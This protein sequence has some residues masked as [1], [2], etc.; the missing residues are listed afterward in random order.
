MP[1]GMDD[2]DKEDIRGLSGLLSTAPSCAKVSGDIMMYNHVLRV[3]AHDS[4]ASWF[5]AAHGPQIKRTQRW[6]ERVRGHVGGN[7]TGLS[8]TW[9]GTSSGAPTL[10]RNNSGIALRSG[11]GDDE[12]VM[13]VDCG[14]P[15]RTSPHLTLMH[16]S[17]CFWR[18]SCSRRSLDRPWE[19]QQPLGTFLALPRIFSV[20]RFEVSQCF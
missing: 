5:Y 18:R 7:P 10:S 17:C 20:A 4:E 11:S 9:L 13:L 3:Q 12:A 1:E 15:H 16:A 8:V 2:D 14:V 19:R 6:L